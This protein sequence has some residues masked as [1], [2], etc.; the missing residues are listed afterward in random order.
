VSAQEAVSDGQSACAGLARQDGPSKLVAL[1]TQRRLTEFESYVVAEFAAQYLCPS[2]A[3]RE[4]S[5][6]QRALLAGS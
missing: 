5:D 6:M 3:P 1:L 2:E 4:A